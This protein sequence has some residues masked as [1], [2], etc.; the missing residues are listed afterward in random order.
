MRRNP[1]LN[2]DSYKFSHYLQY[3]KG[4]EYVYSYIESRGG[5]Y[6]AS[7]M[8]GLQYIL[9]E[10]L[11]VPFNLTDINNAEKIAIAHG[12][13]FNR[14]GFLYILDKY[15]GYWPV[16][17]QAV[18]EGNLVPIGN[19]LVTIVNTD[20]HCAWVTSFLETQL[21]RLWYPITVA[22]REY[23]LRKL[24]E[25]YIT[26]TADD[27]LAGVGFKL[28]DFGARGAS[29]TETS[30]IGGMAHLVSFLGSDNVLALEAAIRYYNATG[31]VG[32]SIPAAEHST[33]TSWGG[34]E[35]E[36]L[37]M[38]NMLD[39]F[40]KPNSLVAVVSDS[41]DLW[42]AIDSYWGGRFLER[43]KNSGGTV[44]VRPDS[45]DP[46]HTAVNTVMQLMNKVGA[47][48]NSKG[49]AILPPYFRVIQGD[50]INEETI[51]EILFKMKQLKLSADNIAFGMGGAM[52]QQ[53]NRDTMKF[54]MKCSAICVDGKWR[55][56]FKDPITDKGKTSK[57]GLVH[58]YKIN[59]KFV[60]TAEPSWGDDKVSAMNTV[61][62]NGRILVDESFDRIKERARLND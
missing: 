49:Y 20:A 18:P 32:F 7:L 45:G 23:Y 40:N 51:S 4:T 62:E 47:T 24:I 2:T 17:I 56:V 21:M 48:I 8:F 60:T 5:A 10:Y 58:L 25:Q 36:P 3:P 41:Y 14:E 29:S 59:N 27:A 11:S 54:A 15:N 9:K 6:P 42:N 1:I 16:R 50:G 30:A 39:K 46:V 52:L 28:N 13:P 44:V 31:P 57:K 35:G 26:E 37:A 38:E 33:M 55:E 12:E 22:T 34:R 43:I 61:F 53:V 19:A